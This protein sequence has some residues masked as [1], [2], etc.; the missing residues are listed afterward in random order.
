[1]TD[2]VRCSHKP[3]LA[4]DFN[5]MI[6]ESPQDQKPFIHVKTPEGQQVW[7][8]IS[9]ITAIYARIDREAY[10]ELS[11]GEGVG[12]FDPPLDKLLVLVNR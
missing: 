5:T 7:I 1:M 8:R 11:N 10:V 2:V 4:P 12:V 3:A 9:S 6:A